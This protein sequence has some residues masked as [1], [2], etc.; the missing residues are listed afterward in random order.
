MGLKIKKG[1]TRN[2]SV[3]EADRQTVGGPPGNELSGGV[4]PTY[5]TRARCVGCVGQLIEVSRRVVGGMA[6]GACRVVSSAY[7]VTVALEP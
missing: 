1:N 5:P 4:P 3:L 7:E 6:V 2:R